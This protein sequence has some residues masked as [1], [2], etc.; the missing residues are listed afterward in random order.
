MVTNDYSKLDWLAGWV[1]RWRWQDLEPGTRPSRAAHYTGW[2]ASQAAIE[3][4]L[5]QH[6][7]IDGLLGGLPARGWPLRDAEE[8]RL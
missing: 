3:E 6:H 8:R 5:Q 2:E 1:R 4:A 7:P